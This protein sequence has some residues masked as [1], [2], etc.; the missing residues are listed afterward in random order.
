MLLSLLNVTRVYQWGLKKMFQLL[1]LQHQFK[2][3]LNTSEQTPQEVRLLRRIVLQ[4]VA[5]QVCQALGWMLVR[6]MNMYT[7]SNSWRGCTWPSCQQMRLHVVNGGQHFW[8]QLAALIW[9]QGMFLSS[10]RFTAW[11]PDAAKDSVRC[12]KH[13]MT[14]WC[15][16]SMLLRGSSSLRF[17]LPILIWHMSW[18]HGLRRVLP[19]KRD[20]RVWLL[21]T[22]SLDTMRLERTIQWLWIRC[23]YL[24]WIWRGRPKRTWQSLWRRPTTFFMGSNLQTDQLRRLC[25]VG[26]GIR[27]RERLCWAEW[28]TRWNPVQEIQERDLLSGYGLRL[29]RRSV[30]ED[31]TLTMR[32]SSRV[33]SLLHPISLHLLLWR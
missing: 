30:S 21:W 19:G 13:Q 12:F 8:L 16:T 2:K 6:R 28:L 17:F 23:T 14:S 20:P 5:H 25:I 33:S 10:F 11:I 27:S 18:L 29:Q 26:F 22:S 3:G 32:T 9:H 24:V 1:V 15:S 4:V 31:M 7:R